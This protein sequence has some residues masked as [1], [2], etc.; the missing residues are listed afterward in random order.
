MENTAILITVIVPVY[1][2]GPHLD[3]VIAALKQQNPPLNR[4]ILSHSGEGDPTDRFADVEGVTVLHS[5]QRLY[6]G[7]ARNRGLEIATTDW[8]AF[9]DEDVIVDDDWHAKLI[10]AIAR[11]DSDCIVGSVGYAESG[12]YWGMSLWFVEFSSVHPYRAPGPI[13]SGASAN[14]A[15]RRELLAS[16]GGFREDWRTGEDSLA[17]AMLG[18]AGYLNRLEPAVC[19]RHVNLPGLR[20]MLR[21]SQRLGPSSARQRR[22]YPHL[23]G[24]VAVRW[25]VLS[26][27]MWI[28]RLLQIYYRVFT[29]R[30]SP[31]LSLIW[32]TPGILICVV[33]WNVGFAKSAFMHYG[34]AKKSIRGCRRK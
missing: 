19:G 11:G 29:R 22:M 33:A 26:L 27:G 14:L 30:H 10:P 20:R 32:H 9:V 18:V 31:K 5:S 3:R 21:H 12:G 17:Q 28:A 2:A 8:V 23:T 25:P 1:G 6:A 13:A 24:S 16:I 7:A 15:V 4:I 34:G